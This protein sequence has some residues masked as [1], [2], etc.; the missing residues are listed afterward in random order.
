MERKEQEGW[1]RSLEREENTNSVQ[2]SGKVGKTG[3]WY[4]RES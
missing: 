4:D 3:P 2:V 1:D